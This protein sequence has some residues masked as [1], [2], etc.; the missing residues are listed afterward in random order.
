MQ[1]KKLKLSHF[2]KFQ[3]KEIDLK[4]GIN[5]IYGDNEA[6]K[7]TIHAFIKG[8]LFGIDRMR[9]RG[10]ASKEDTYT[11]YLPWDYPGAYA[12]TMDIQI[13]EREYRLQRSFHANDKY[14]TVLDLTTGREIKLKEG[15]IS[16]I[17][18]GLTETAFKNTVSIEQLKAQ[19][20]AGLAEE[21][22]NYIANLSMAKAKEVNVT[23][24]ISTLSEKKKSLENAISKDTSFK[25]SI[26]TE[27]EE[28]LMKEER[29][30][31][32]TLQLKELLGK[33]QELKKIIDQADTEKDREER[34][35]I[36][37]LPAILEKYHIYQEMT[38]S[39]LH[40]DKQISELTE[41]INLWKKTGQASQELQEDIL[42]SGRL[43]AAIPEY[44]LNLTRLYN[45]RKAA[46]QAAALRSYGIGISLAFVMILLS[47]LAA[48]TVSSR[49][50]MSIGSV[51]TV[52]LFVS[53]LHKKSKEK[54]N[55]K[56]SNIE[57]LSVQLSQA[58][59]RLSEILYKNKVTTPEELTLKQA[60]NLQNTL[61]L[62]HKE[63]QLKELYY[64]KNELD[65]NRDLLHDAIMKYIQFFI[66][67]EELSNDAI[68]RLQDEI[69]HRKL[70]QSSKHSEA[71]KQYDDC[72]LQ[73]EKLKWELTA[74]ED[75][76][77]KLLKNKAVLNTLERKQRENNTELCAVKLALATIQELSTDIHDSFGIQLNK[78]VSDIIGDITNEKYTDLKIDEKLEVKAG[79]NGNY[80]ILDRLSAGT[81]DQI[82]F[83]L[84]IAVA[85]L[86]LGKNEMP[87]I[88][89]DSF[90]LYDDN[91]V[92]YALMQIAD[93]KQILLFSCHNRE[94]VLLEEL[95]LPYHYV[96][97]SCR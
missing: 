17:V 16:E 40:L 13:G 45:E 20:D 64:R 82:Y 77:A 48:E 70:E 5:L 39:S 65:D 36:D 83:A 12:G 78:A 97:L 50:F 6:G 76:E 27:I 93:R 25:K 43:K 90:A 9:G 60:E 96:D 4:P 89:D 52:G 75:N 44:E 63:E 49:I 38:L 74:L 35:R 19:T 42:E 84:R 86:L 61:A 66:R 18:P 31:T 72:K 67:E 1:L 3:G 14:F 85:D 24:A 30:D 23:Q 80:I 68:R 47:F 88:L 8:M 53:L 11:R 32:L 54:S 58:K 69:H 55:Q 73:I 15:L 21:V 92:K 62:T 22:R 81:M 91:R 10:A 26:E 29:M 41:V 37:Q 95:K 2:G 59:D 51:C 7:S 56:D 87:L 46:L 33:E 28:G 94:K 71:S 57:S 79:W 34:M